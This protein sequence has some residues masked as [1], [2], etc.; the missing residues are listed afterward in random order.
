MKSDEE[1]V[2]LV[3]EKVFGWIE[4]VTDG[5]FGTIKNEPYWVTIVD[6]S[7]SAFSSIFAVHCAVRTFDPLEND[8][9][10]CA[11]LDKMAADGW[12]VSLEGDNKGYDGDW[13][14]SF[15]S[16]EGCHDKFGYWGSGGRRRVIVIAALRAKGVDV[17]C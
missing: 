2:R 10:N 13:Y 7:K 17:G 15:A 1:L 9:W 12:L 5:I 6:A 16:N 4:R 8:K 3:A 11:V 14:C